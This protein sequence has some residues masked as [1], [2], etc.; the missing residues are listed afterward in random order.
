MS[1]QQ[2]M[3]ELF[4]QIDDHDFSVIDK[5]HA[6]DCTYRM[7]YDTMEGGAQF[8][9]MMAAWYGAFPDLRHEMLEYV[10]EGERAAFTLRVV[11][12]HTGT[13][14]TPRGDIPATGKRV[15]FRVV[16]VVAFG[17]DGKAVKW[18]VYFDMLQMLQQLGLAPAA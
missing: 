12:T 3:K 15:D 18:N 16:D 5:A 8:R 2:A 17:A 9:A 11:G 13:M 4:R 14:H 1:K 10:E 7:N 6:A